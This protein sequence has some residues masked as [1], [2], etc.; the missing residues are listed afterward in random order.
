[1]MGKHKQQHVSDGLEDWDESVGEAAT[2]A[3]M[4]GAAKRVAASLST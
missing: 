1:M 3:H 2:R 4:V